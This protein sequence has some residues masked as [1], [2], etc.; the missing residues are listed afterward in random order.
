M[1]NKKCLRRGAV[2][3]RGVQS[4]SE[5]QKRA[6]W[7]MES[8]RKAPEQTGEV[9]RGTRGA[10]PALGHDEDLGRH[11]EQTTDDIAEVTGPTEGS[12]SGLLQVNY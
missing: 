3:A 8:L 5:N 2:G 12:Q 4:R 9:L 10:K 6:V 1:D 11:S 7:H